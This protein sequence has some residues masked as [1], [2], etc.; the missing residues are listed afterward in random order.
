MISYVL[1]YFPICLHK[2]LIFPYHL[3]FLRGGGGLNM[4]F[5]AMQTSSLALDRYR[6]HIVQSCLHDIA[7]LPTSHCSEPCN[8]FMRLHV[9]LYDMIFCSSDFR[10]FSRGLQIASIQNISEYTKHEQTY[11]SGKS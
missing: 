9:V 10:W 8:M 4:T 1:Y 11:K 7:R 3:F 5:S 2:F 6:C